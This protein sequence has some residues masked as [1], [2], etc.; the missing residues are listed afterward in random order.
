MDFLFYDGGMLLNLST[1]SGKMHAHG[2]EVPEHE[3]SLLLGSKVRYYKLTHPDR[4]LSMDETGDTGD[5]SEDNPT[6]G[7][8]S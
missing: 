6:Q 7:T 1:H 5:Q 2:N 3:A 4:I 8:I